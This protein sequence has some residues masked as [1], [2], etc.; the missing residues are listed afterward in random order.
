MISPCRLKGVTID[1]S[2]P[3]SMIPMTWEAND[4]GRIASE[5]S[6]LVTWSVVPS[7]ITWANALD[8]LSSV[9]NSSIGEAAASSS[10]FTTS[11]ERDTCATLRDKPSSTNKRIPARERSD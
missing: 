6:L 4:S 3:I 9:L 7:F 8:S 2:P 10:V 11:E 1:G 5:M